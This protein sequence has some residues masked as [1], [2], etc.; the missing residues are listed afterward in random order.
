MLPYEFSPLDLEHW[1]HDPGFQALID[2]VERLK[3]VQKKGRKP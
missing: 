1:L 3:E 2:L